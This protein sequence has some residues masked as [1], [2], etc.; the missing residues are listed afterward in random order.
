LGQIVEPAV[1]PLIEALSDE[2]YGVCMAAAEA[3]GRIG[4]PRAVEP[5]IVALKNGGWYMIRKAA[6]EALGRIGDPRAVEPLIPVLKDEYFKVREAATEALIKIGAPSVEP[7]ID[8]LRYREWRMR[9]AA[10]EVLGKIGDARAIEPLIA[11]L[12][13]EDKDVRKSVAWGLV[14]LSHNAPLDDEVKQRILSVL[15][16]G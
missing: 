15:P 16:L 13:D 7:L 11:A 8:A 5:L 10:T 9:K 2:Y 12:E 1:K 6:A 4:D 3:L 14:S